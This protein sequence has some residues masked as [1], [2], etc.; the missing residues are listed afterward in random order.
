MHTNYKFFDEKG[1]HLHTLGNNPLF[2]TSTVLQV[3]S[4]NLT[5]WAAELAAVEC[6]ENGEQ[7]PTIRA[8]YEEACKQPDKKAAIDALQKKYPIF[9]AARF[10][11]FATKNKK[12]EQGTDMHAE[13]EKYVKW[14]IEGNGGMPLEPRIGEAI[15]VLRFSDWAI[16]NVNKF[17][18]TE[19][20]CY[21]EA[22][23]CGGITDCM[24]LMKNG[25]IAIIDFKSA[26]EAY[27]SMFLQVAAYDLQQA[28]NGI[29]DADGN[30]ILEPQKVEEYYVIPFG[31]PEFKVAF[32]V[33]TN[34]LRD[35][36]RAAVVLHKLLNK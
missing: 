6:L 16:S 31:A 26:K 13:L 29:F 1:A 25:K 15:Q 19:G 36:F 30:K 7:I 18:V 9:K 11:H 22:L 27:D 8:E 4:K 35:G 28:E 14:C 10:A 5:W 20:H 17:L 12:A 21:S 23:W 34:E 33:A 2:G 3:I 24:A 32:R